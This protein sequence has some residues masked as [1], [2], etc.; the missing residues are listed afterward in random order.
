MYPC[1]LN[2]VYFA[3]AHPDLLLKQSTCILVVYYKLTVYNVHTRGIRIWTHF[4]DSRQVILPI[5][6]NPQHPATTSP[7]RNQSIC[8]PLTGSTQQTT[9][10]GMELDIRGAK[11]FSSPLLISWCI[12]PRIRDWVL[13]LVELYNCMHRENSYSNDPAHALKE[14]RIGAYEFTTL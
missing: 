8:T 6:H 14:K 13:V 2:D 3:A 9:P 4:D 1:I 10:Q 5:T 11:Q 7:Q 12:C